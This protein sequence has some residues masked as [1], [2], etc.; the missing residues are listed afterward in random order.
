MAPSADNMVSK[1]Y[2]SQNHSDARTQM[3]SRQ[4][5]I[6]V[7]HDPNRMYDRG[8]SKLNL[9]VSA[10]SRL[11]LNHHLLSI[12]HLRVRIS[13]H[14]K[15]QRANTTTGA[16][17]LASVNPTDGKYAESGYLVGR[18]SDIACRALCRVLRNAP[19]RNRPRY[20]RSQVAMKAGQVAARQGPF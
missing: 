8:V 14:T 4:I 20:S 7:T 11:A 12:L 17:P 19:A 2:P 6:S 3:Y 13:K 5:E 15:S 10:A 18:A 1:S 9:S 16:N